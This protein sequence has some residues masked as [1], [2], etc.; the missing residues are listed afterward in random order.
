MRILFLGDVVGRSGRDAVAAG[1][2]KLRAD[3]RADL[4]VVNGENASHGFGLAPDMA[5]AILAAGAD[6]ITLG[7]HA[8]DRQA[9]S[10][11]YIA[12]EPRLAAPSSTSRPARPAAARSWR[13]ACGTGGRALV[14]NANGPLV[15]GPAGLP[16]P[17]HR[18]NCFRGYTLGANDRRRRLRFPRRG[19]QRKNVICPQLLTDRSQPG[20]RHP[21]PHP[22]RRPPHPARRHSVPVG[23]RHVRRLRQRDRHGQGR[24]RPCPFLAEDARR[25]TRASRRPGRPSAAC[26][27]KP[28]MRRAWPA[29][30]EPIRT[31]G[32]LA[33]VMP[34]A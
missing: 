8:W 13:H 32:R 5:E 26:S 3:L 18:R 4:V 22:H 15:H 17:R 19:D 7:N 28:M 16:V 6:A 11:P 9:R 10:F 34:T 21:Y 23:R 24:Q 30:I 20:G 29:R 12:Q 14:M 31:G 33:Q 27:S 2:P 25:E 1:L